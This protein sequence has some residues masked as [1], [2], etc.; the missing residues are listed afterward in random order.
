MLPKQKEV[1]PVARDLIQR[2][3]CDAGTRIGM[4]GGIDEIKVCAD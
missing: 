2:F 3:C 4:A 1:S